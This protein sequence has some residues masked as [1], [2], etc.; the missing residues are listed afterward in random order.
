MSTLVVN[1]NQ[2]KRVSAM[3][4]EINYDSILIT[5]FKVTSV[6]KSL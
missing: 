2:A 3:D 4:N 5:P 1:R 6:T